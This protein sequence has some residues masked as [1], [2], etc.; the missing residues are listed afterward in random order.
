MQITDELLYQYAPVAEAQIMEK[1]PGADE[2]PK[3]KFSKR[4]ER[5]MARLIAREKRS[6]RMRRAITAAKRVAVFLLVCSALTISCLMTVEAF[7]MK[8]I[9][10][11]TEVFE[12]LTHFSFLSPVE[13]SDEIGE[14][15]F[16]YLPENME[17]VSLEIDD[18]ILSQRILFQNTEGQQLT[19][20]QQSVGSE[21]G[22]DVILDTENSVTYKTIID[23]ED[24][25]VVTKEEW[26]AI[27]WSDEQ[28]VWLLQGECAPN[29]LVKVANGISIKK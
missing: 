7:R 29:E 28:N 15:T 8:V 11:V 14:L 19:V 10:I 21:S 13:S 23:G 3:H 18:T 20:I 5:K 27:I 25:T 16:S 1:Y 17:E 12:D 9:E 24:A 2:L 4:F 22:Y 26:S 6:P